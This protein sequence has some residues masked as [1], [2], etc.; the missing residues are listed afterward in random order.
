MTDG[1]VGPDL[2]GGLRGATFGLKGAIVLP[3]TYHISYYDWPASR[4]V[5][6][7]ISA[8]I[9]SSFQVRE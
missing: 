7:M 9:L 2:S 5:D 6:T 4:N 8:S 1:T 3:G